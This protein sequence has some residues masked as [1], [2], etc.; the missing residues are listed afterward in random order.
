MGRHGSG[1]GSPRTTRRPNPFVAQSGRSGWR[2][3]GILLLLLRVSGPRHLCRVTGAP[4][5]TATPLLLPGNPSKQL[6]C[7]SLLLGAGPLS[8][9]P[10]R[11]ALA[12]RLSLT[13]Q[14]DCALGS[15]VEVRVSHPH[16]SGQQWRRRPRKDGCGEKTDGWSPGCSVA[17]QRTQLR[18]LTVIFSHQKVVNH[19]QIVPFPESLRQFNKYLLSANMC[20]RH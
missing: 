19:V 3:A 12:G 9:Q 16:G 18:L 14:P 10:L 1:R 7:P 11:H 6:P 20:R 17:Q 15:P 4:A 13:E 8:G 2:C 5:S